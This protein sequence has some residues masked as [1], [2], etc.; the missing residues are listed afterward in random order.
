MNLFNNIQY[1]TLLRNLLIQ[2][3]EIS[4]ENTTNTVNSTDPSFINTLKNTENIFDED[5]ELCCS[6]C[7][8]NFKKGDRYIILPCSSNKHYFHY[9]NE[10]CSGIL[11]WLEINNTCPICREILPT[12][13]E[14]LHELQSTEQIVQQFL[15]RNTT[16]VL[17]YRT[18]NPE[19][20]DLNQN[21]SVNQP[22]EIE[23]NETESNS[24]T[25]NTLTN[26]IEVINEDIELNLA[27]QRSLTDI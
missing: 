16:S 4:S 12:V 19:P 27:I 23:L 1:N 25:E 14:N 8:D 15:D 6:I 9:G 10:S 24:Q 20:S 13:E 3:S 2:I 17:L 7:I 18:M 21:Q 11:P 22:N 5:T 26:F